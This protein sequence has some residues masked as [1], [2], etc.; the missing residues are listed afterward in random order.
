MAAGQLS[1]KDEGEVGFL[2]LKLTIVKDLQ[3]GLVP[4]LSVENGILLDAHIFHYTTC[5][6][7][8]LELNGCLAASPLASYFC[9][10]F[11]YFEPNQH[12]YNSE[13]CLR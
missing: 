7:F 10:L 1:S 5:C 2:M 4:G 6:S 8:P 12:W 3:T 9:F 11:C 13:C